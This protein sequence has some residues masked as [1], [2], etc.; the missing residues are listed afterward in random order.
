MLGHPEESQDGTGTDGC[1][2]AA[3]GT[4]DGIMFFFKMY[5]NL[6][7]LWTPSLTSYKPCG[8]V[9]LVTRDQLS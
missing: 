2:G 3:E 4:D 6:P 9:A 8:F 7:I 5:R 1:L